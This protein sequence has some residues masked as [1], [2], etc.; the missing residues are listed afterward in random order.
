[1]IRVDLFSPDRFSIHD[2]S[3][4]SQK[5]PLQETSSHH[6][7]AA[8]EP[9]TKLIAAILFRAED[10]LRQAIA[11]LET[12]FSP[13]DHLGAAH[14]FDRT[15]YYRAEMGGGLRRELVSFAVLVSPTELAGAKHAAAAVEDALRDPAGNRTVNVDMG[16]L[17]LFKVVLASFKARG[18]KLYLGRGVWADLTLTY[19]KGRFYSFPWTF[20]DFGGDGSGVDNTGGDASGG[21]YHADLL[22]IRERYRQQLREGKG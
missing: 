20:P 3:P 19:S 7:S 14:F 10:G 4:M 5:T 13:V 17:D 9:Q 15:D 2:A 6:P 22:A 16:Y 8:Q 1:M 21:R 18:Q 11:R 12:A